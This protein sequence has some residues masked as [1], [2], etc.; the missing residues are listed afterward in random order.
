MHGACVP[1]YKFALQKRQRG[2][3]IERDEQ[4]DIE[5]SRTR[6]NELTNRKVVSQLRRILDLETAVRMLPS[7]SA[8]GC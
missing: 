8:S 5:N 4:T 7:V 2:T 3:D 1:R 6:S